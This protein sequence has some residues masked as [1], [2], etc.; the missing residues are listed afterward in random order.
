MQIVNGYI[1]S[2][3]LSKCKIYFLFQ[4]KNGFFFW[5]RFE[6][7]DVAVRNFAGS[8]PHPPSNIGMCPVPGPDLVANCPCGPASD[9]GPAFPEPPASASPDGT[10]PS[11][12]VT[13]PS[14]PSGPAERISSPAG[15]HSRPPPQ[16]H[17]CRKRP[18]VLLRQ[19]AGS[20]GIVDLVHM[21]LGERMSWASPPSLVSS[22]NPSVSLSS[23]PTGNSPRR[24]SSGGSKSSTVAPGRPPWRRGPPQAYE[25]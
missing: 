22:S 19:T 23:R 21:M 8:L 25:A 10:S 9:R 11:R 18:A 4:Q 1:I 5:A 24:R 13:S 2:L 7:S 6:F 16:G 20:A 3:N 15:R 14:L 12:R 17:A